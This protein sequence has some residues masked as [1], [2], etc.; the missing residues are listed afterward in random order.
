MGPTPSKRTDHTIKCI[1]IS[2]HLGYPSSKRN[3]RRR[4]RSRARGKAHGI[5]SKSLKYPVR[6]SPPI[7]IFRTNRFNAY[8]EQQT[9]KTGSRQYRNGSILQ[10]SAR[11]IHPRPTAR[12]IFERNVI[13]T[14]HRRRRGIRA[15]H[16]SKE[17]TVCST[18]VSP[19]GLSAR[20]RCSSIQNTSK[21][22]QNADFPP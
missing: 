5:K 3:P 7:K 14:N 8:A 4:C 17:Q 18:G 2:L 6:K 12:R 11:M 9:R 13:G 1:E 16:N 20:Q 19:V 10:R 21:Q 22:P 15:I